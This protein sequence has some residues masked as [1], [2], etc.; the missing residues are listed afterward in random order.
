MLCSKQKKKPKQDKVGQT[1]PKA[2][3]SVHE[4]TGRSQEEKIGIDSHLNPQSLLEGRHRYQ[5]IIRKYVEWLKYTSTTNKRYLNITK[6][7]QLQRISMENYPGKRRDNEVQRLSKALKSSKA[8]N[9]LNL[10]LI[11]T[12][13]K[14][15]RDLAISL[16]RPSSLSI[17]RLK[18]DSHSQISNAGIKRLFIGLKYL[19]NLSILSLDFA[20]CRGIT[21]EAVEI[22]ASG[23]RHLN[24]L[25]VL[26]LDFISC[27][28]LTDEAVSSISKRLRHIQHLVSLSLV[29]YG[30]ENI[31]NAPFNEL[32]QELTRLTSLTTLALDF[33]GCV[34][35]NDEALKNLSQALECLVSLITLKLKFNRCGFTEKGIE[36]VCLS[37]APL[38]MLKNL[39]LYFLFWSN[40]EIAK[41]S[42]NKYLHDRSILKN[43]V[44]D[45]YKC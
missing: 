11:G 41:E 2:Q 26:Y 17:L 32:S 29:F 10:K 25:S 24:Y 44:V 28:Q 3:S 18:F 31:T 9:I 15:I 30:C 13:N 7:P 23:L 40:N 5:N 34:H 21:D 35:V 27:S 14:D 20:N 39:R 8:L 16:R 43:V 37:L 33:G 4:E 42:I 19:N 12:A 45:G 22:L 6:L 1:L 36:D 38:K